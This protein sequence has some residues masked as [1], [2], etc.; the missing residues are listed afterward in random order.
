MRRRIITTDMPISMS[1]MGLSTE[2]RGRTTPFSR[3]LRMGL[4]DLKRRRN[5]TAIAVYNMRTTGSTGS[6]EPFAADMMRN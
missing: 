5:S 1:F 3:M 2:P 4:S 6:V